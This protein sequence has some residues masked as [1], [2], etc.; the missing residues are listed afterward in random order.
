MEYFKTYCNIL[1]IKYLLHRVI[2]KNTSFLAIEPRDP[3][4]HLRLFLILKFA[5]VE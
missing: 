5:V 3:A 1:L 4:F 2:I